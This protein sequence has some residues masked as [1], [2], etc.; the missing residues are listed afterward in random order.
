MGL[1]VPVPGA[2][3]I[4]RSAVTPRSADDTA[5]DL[6]QRYRAEPDGTVRT[7]LHT[8]SPCCPSRRPAGGHRCTVQPWLK[9][10]M[11]GTASQAAGGGARRCVRGR[12]WRCCRATIGAP[13]RAPG[14]VAAAAV[15]GDS[16]H[17]RRHPLR[18]GRLRRPPAEANPDAVLPRRASARCGRGPPAGPQ[19][20]LGP[21]LA[22]PAAGTRP[23]RQ[24]A[25]PVAPRRLKP[26]PR[27]TARHHPPRP[28]HPRG[29]TD[30]AH[31]GT[32]GRTRDPKPDR[33]PDRGRPRPLPRPR[34][35]PAGPEYTLNS[36]SACPSHQPHRLENPWVNTTYTLLSILEAGP[37]SP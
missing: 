20:P 1:P 13:R 22:D 27:S 15:A 2:S 35:N 12:R 26:A 6:Q 10:R 23:D 19:P 32:D 31:T 24:P 16:G 8:P 4:T 30:L 33:G 7:R 25:L 34:F 11:G 21:G 9:P 17:A 36:G 3:A 28:R 37:T 5:K 14:A 29:P 18:A